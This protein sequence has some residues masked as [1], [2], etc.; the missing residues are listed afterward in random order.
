MVTLKEAREE[1]KNKTISNRDQMMEML[2]KYDNKTI[3]T[4]L[5]DT[6]KYYSQDEDILTGQ[7]MMVLDAVHKIL[8]KREMIDT[9]NNTWTLEE[10][11]N[12]IPYHSDIVDNE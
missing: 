5:I 9:R 12:D 6:M 8:T 3:I 10:F 11:L 1:I 7:Y 2:D 4:W